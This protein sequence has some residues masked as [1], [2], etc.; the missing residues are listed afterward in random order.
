MFAI[1]IKEINSFL[2]SLIAYMVITAFLT[3]IGLNTWVFSD[4]SVLNFG[5]AD[6]NT[7]F[8]FG[9]LA[10]LLLIPAITMKTF[11][12][13]KKEGTIELLL[14]RPLSDWD[15]ILGKYFSS[16]GLVVV[17]LLPTLIYYFSIYT[18]GNP[19]GNI[20]SAAV[21]SSYTGLLLL[22]A[23]FTGIGIFSSVITK[24]QVIS[25][26]ICLIL[27]Y[28]LYDGIAQIASINIWSSNAPFIASLGLGYHYDALS[29]GLIDSRDVFYFISIIAIML[30]LTHKILGSRK[31]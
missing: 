13:E 12:E 30:L 29:R 19:P 11:A 10:F 20:D 16:L 23:V 2:N 17:A 6:M 7:L 31:W 28:F 1:F 5:Y 26:L 4:T 8:E 15:I 21:F 27:C 22:A 25:F 24:N 14:T 3:F 18:L 9:P